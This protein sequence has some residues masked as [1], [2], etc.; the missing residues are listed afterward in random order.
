[1]RISVFAQFGFLPLLHRPEEER[2][3]ERRHFGEP[4]SLFLSLSLSP[5]RAARGRCPERL[6][7]K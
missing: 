6:A 7:K 3:G 5:L 1:V 2:V 4:L